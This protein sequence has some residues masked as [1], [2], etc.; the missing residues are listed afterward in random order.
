M[1]MKK[2][3]VDGLLNTGKSTTTKTTIIIMMMITFPVVAVA[4]F[5]EYSVDLVVEM[6]MMMMMTVVVEILL[7]NHADNGHISKDKNND[8]NNDNDNDCSFFKR[9]TRF[10]CIK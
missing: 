3:F 8:N 5:C 2:V 7:Y 4:S 6:M 1:K 9:R 10:I